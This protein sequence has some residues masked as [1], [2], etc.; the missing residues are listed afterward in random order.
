M[1][2]FVESNEELLALLD[3][4][5]YTEVPALP[6][7]WRPTLQREGYPQVSLLWIN[8]CKV[9]GINDFLTF[10]EAWEA[11]LNHDPS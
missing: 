9:A 11:I 4:I 1:N 7:A 5:G 6:P 10:T 3:L 2:T 8:G